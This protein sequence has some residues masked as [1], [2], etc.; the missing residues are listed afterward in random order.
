MAKP[1][2]LRIG[3]AKDDVT[4][5]PVT[6]PFKQVQWSAGEIREKRWL[7]VVPNEERGAG[8]RSGHTKLAAATGAG[9]EESAATT[10]G[11]DACPS[12]GR[13]SVGGGLDA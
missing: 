4:K 7:V 10:T 5:R 3:T 2:Q 9:A 6:V 11:L 8:F 13:V 12:R 1:L